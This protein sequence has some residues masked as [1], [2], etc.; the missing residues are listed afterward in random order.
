MRL[1]K[2][3]PAAVGENVTKVRHVVPAA[4]GFGALGQSVL[5]IAKS[6]E[7]DVVV[8]NGPVPE[9]RMNA[10]AAELVVPRSTE[11]KSI[12]EGVMVAAGDPAGVMIP[13]PNSHV[14][15]MRPPDP[16]PPKS[17]VRLRV[18]SKAAAAPYLGEGEPAGLS[19]VHVL[20]SNS[21]VSLN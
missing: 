12:V 5:E 17:T 14:S 7:V 16:W 11:P 20:P 15:A 13:P 1:P 18:G 21:H 19:C 4:R 3:S 10:A 9:L 2:R 6:P 8:T